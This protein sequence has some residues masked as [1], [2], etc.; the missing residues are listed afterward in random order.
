MDSVLTAKRMCDKASY[1][2]IVTQ[3]IEACMRH[4]AENI[5]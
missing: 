4:F 5:F 1:K 2:Q 3:F